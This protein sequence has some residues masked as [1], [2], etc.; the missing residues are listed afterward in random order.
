MTRYVA[1]I[2]AALLPGC[3]TSSGTPSALARTDV[4]ERPESL[5]QAQAPLRMPIRSVVCLTS[6]CIYV[7]SPNYGGEQYDNKVT[8]Y[9]ANASGDVPPVDRIKGKRTKMFVSSGVAVDAERNVY[10]LNTDDYGSVTVYAAGS[11]GNVRPVRDIRGPDTRMNSPDD[12]AVDVR[13]NVY[14]VNNGDDSVT[15]YGP[16][17]YGDARP[18]QRIAGPDTGL[19]NVQGVAVDA[20]DDIYV[21]N[22]PDGPGD[23]G[24]IVTVYT[25]GANGDIAPT[26]TITGSTT[27]LGQP[28]GIAVDAGSNIY[29]ANYRADSV[30]V[31]AA[32]VSGDVAPIQTISG[33]IT[34]LR[35]PT[36]VAVDSEK[37]IYVTNSP[38]F[39]T[40]YAAGANGNVAPI[41]KIKGEKASLHLADAIAVR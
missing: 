19:D 15:V 11:H 35:N 34:D 17:A 37:R 27:G 39:V 20:H 1:L 29:V 7:V 14:V 10:V 24:G 28:E 36:G 18:L 38:A 3:V 5:G 16:K 12:V 8:M 30:T 13:S 21:A 4:T 9:P 40:V 26:Q 33:S 2:A 41:Q 31:F 23:G 6:P 32:G 25:A 22:A